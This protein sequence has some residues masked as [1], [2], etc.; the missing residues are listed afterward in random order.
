MLVVPTRPKKE[1][2]TPFG[3]VNPGFEQARVRNIAVTIT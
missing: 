3:L 2:D 1:P